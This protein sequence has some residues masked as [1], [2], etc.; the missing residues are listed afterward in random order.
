MNIFRILVLLSILS[1]FV[2]AEPDLTPEEERWKNDIIS[3]QNKR[4]SRYWLIFSTHNGGMPFG[5]FHA[6]TIAY[7]MDENGQNYGRAPGRGLIF[8]MTFEYGPDGSFIDKG[9]SENVRK[10]SIFFP[11]PHK[12]SSSMRRIEKAAS[13]VMRSGYRDTDYHYY[14]N[15]CVTYSCAM[16]RTLVNRCGGEPMNGIPPL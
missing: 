12:I 1:L 13:I 9:L 8:Q 7:L 16:H 11:G 3:E 4:L 15:N 2:F 10:G 14:K 6:T 5:N